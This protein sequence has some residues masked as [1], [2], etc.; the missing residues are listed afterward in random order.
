[1]T[2]RKGKTDLIKRKGKAESKNIVIVVSCT[3][4][5]RSNLYQTVVCDIPVSGKIKMLT[6]T[7][8]LKK[9]LLPQ[10]TPYFLFFL[11]CMLQFRLAQY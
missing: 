5:N 3:L 4:V 1:M 8:V 9:I 2:K 7:S 6:F 11:I 10:E